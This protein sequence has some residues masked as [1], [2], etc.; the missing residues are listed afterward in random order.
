MKNVFLLPT[1]NKS[2][3]V[4]LKE[5]NRLYYHPMIL[6]INP[7]IIPQYVYITT[8]EKF[9]ENEYLTDGIEVIQATLKLVEAQGLVDR[10]KWK[11]IIITNDPELIENGVQKVTHSF[12]NWLS[13]NQTCERV[14]IKTIESDECNCYY[15]KLC[16]STDL[17]YKTHCSD[18]GKTKT[19]YEII[20]PK[21]PTIDDGWLSPM[22]RFRLREDKP[23][24]TQ[25]PKITLEL[26]QEEARGLL[27]CLMRTSANGKD[28]D[29]GEM[30]EE[31]LWEFLKPLE[32]K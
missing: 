2:N 12:L 21:E 20:T 25:E 26:T 17:D 23:S 11:K 24:T 10:R 13:E 22:Q 8:E 32:N 6:S 18:G 5:N 28:L 16:K 4:L 15:S 14:E 27:N 30:V 1:E 9:T 19:Y 31:K 3:I 29:V 7:N